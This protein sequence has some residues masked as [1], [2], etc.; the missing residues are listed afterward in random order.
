ME[1]GLIE[2]ESEKTTKK[3]KID[4]P[5][6]LVDVKISIENG[7]AKEVTFV[8]IPAFLL[9]SVTVNVEG[10]GEISCDIAYGGNF[11]ELLMQKSLELILRIIMLLKLLIK[12]SQ[13]VIRSICRKKSS[14]LSSLLL[15]A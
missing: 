8:N 15:M 1:A 14:T 11:M 3:L 5:A 12:P 7:K 13:S 2:Y 9:K 6:G 4:T 10:I